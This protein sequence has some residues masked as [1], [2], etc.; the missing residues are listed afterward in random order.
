MALL[1]VTELTGPYPSD[2]STAGQEA[3]TFVAAAASGGD[4]FTFTGRE[5]LLVW[6]DGGSGVSTVTVTSVASALNN[7][8][9]N[10]LAAVDVDGHVA[11]GPFT[12]GDGW[13]SGG[14][15]TVSVSSPTNVKLA[16]LR[17]PTLR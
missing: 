4:T 3:V 14:L 13:V 12:H 17:M 16:V 15:I 1:T 11:L 8:S 2:L 6:K 7:R 9:G 5:I 10:M